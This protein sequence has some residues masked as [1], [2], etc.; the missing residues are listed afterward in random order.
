MPVNAQK[1][2]V[3][4]ACCNVTPARGAASPSLSACEPAPGMSGVKTIRN[5]TCAAP[6]HKNTAR[7]PALARTAVSAA[8]MASC[9]TLMPAVATPLAP[10]ARPGMA[11]VT[12]T[13]T[14]VTEPMPF[15]SAKKN[16]YN[17]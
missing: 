1:R 5:N 6:S 11:R 8:T 4:A 9:P 17:T 2:R 7:Q 14:G 10:P 12:I 3:P 16:P 13:L 15:P